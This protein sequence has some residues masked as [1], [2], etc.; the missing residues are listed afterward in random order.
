MTLPSFRRAAAA[1]LLLLLPTGLL[2]AANLHERIED[3]IHIL[4][5]KQH[6]DEPI[7]AGLLNHAKGVAF[8]TVTKAGLG[9]GGLGG[10]GIVLVHLANGPGPAWSAPSA[11][12]LA[13]GS[14]GAQIG[15]T[16]VQYIAVLNTNDAVRHFTESGKMNWDATATGTAG[17]ASGTERVTSTELEHREIVIYKSSG[18]VFGGAT[19][20]GTSLERKYEINEAAYGEGVRT[21]DILSGK[22]PPPPLA[23]RLYALL[24]G[25]A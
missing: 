5:Q 15:F 25:K 24:D 2:R 17:D 3:A 11:F 6:S 9:I 20:G 1:C 12:N 7:P 18:G 14:I 10:E 19:L 23:G 16:Q 21:R 8:F 4:E 13:G 22:I